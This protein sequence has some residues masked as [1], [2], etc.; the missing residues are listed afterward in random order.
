MDLVRASNGSELPAPPPDVTSQ[1]FLSSAGNGL[2]SWTL[3]LAPTRAREL[4]LRPAGRRGPIHRHHPLDAH[5]ETEPAS[6]AS[7]RSEAAPSLKIQ[8]RLP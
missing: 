4:S 1:A 2:G 3:A 8:T 5:A 6:Q 7:G